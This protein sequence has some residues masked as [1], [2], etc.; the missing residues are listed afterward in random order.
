M[1]EHSTI[2]WEGREIRLSYSPRW[3]SCI[4]H[5]E[6]QA[7]DKLPLPITE[8]GY[9]SHFFGPL[10]PVL[11][12]EEAKSMMIE[13]LVKEAAREPWQKHLLSS[14]QLSLF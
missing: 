3:A 13:W 5:V 10:E 12:L 9:R 8:T 4:D 1:A 11:T 2:I 14:Q 6:V 7:L